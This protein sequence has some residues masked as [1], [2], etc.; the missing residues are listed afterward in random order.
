MAV[1]DNQG[2]VASTTIALFATTV[3]LLASLAIYQELHSKWWPVAFLSAT[4]IVSALSIKIFN[5]E[6]SF[7]KVTAWIVLLVSLFMAIVLSMLL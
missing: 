1:S 3:V 5:A 4:S 7:L 6:L 2:C